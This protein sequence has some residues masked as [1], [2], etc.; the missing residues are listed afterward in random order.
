MYFIII[1]HWEK[2]INNIKRK[3]VQRF[4]R[5]CVCAPGIRNNEVCTKSVT[6]IRQTHKKLSNFGHIKLNILIIGLN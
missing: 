6:E 1:D 2:P 4:L 5:V 3:M